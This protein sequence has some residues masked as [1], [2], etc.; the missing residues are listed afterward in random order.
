MNDVTLGEGSESGLFAIT[1]NWFICRYRGYEV[2]LNGANAW[3]DLVA[4]PPA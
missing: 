1:D 4:I 3:S 2:N